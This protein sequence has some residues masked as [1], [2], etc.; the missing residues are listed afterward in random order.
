MFTAT[1]D[2]LHPISFKDI[3][4]ME[5]VTDQSYATALRYVE[6]DFTSRT[7]FQQ[8]FSVFRNGIKELIHALVSLR[9]VMGLEF[10]KNNLQ[11]VFAIGTDNPKRMDAVVSNCCT[12]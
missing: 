7:E 4:E 2:K 5:N 10:F 11:S 1:A 3:E 6:L 8:F 9:P 12:Q